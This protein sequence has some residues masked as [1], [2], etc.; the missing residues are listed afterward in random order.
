MKDVIAE[1]CRLIFEDVMGSVRDGFA[2]DNFLPFLV[3][4]IPAQGGQD[5]LEI[6][7]VH[8]RGMFA[9]VNRGVTFHFFEDFEVFLDGWHFE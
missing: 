7:F 9:S 3:V 2:T 6:F 1:S 8:E 5:V 4:A